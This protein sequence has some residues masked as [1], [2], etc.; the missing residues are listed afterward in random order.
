M[1]TLKKTIMGYGK[2]VK[3][4][5]KLE[6]DPVTKQFAQELANSVIRPAKMGNKMAF[7]TQNIEG[8]HRQKR[9]TPWVDNQIKVFENYKFTDW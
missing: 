3:K 9:S 7:N 1:D 5:V 4:S 2:R 6:K 8:I